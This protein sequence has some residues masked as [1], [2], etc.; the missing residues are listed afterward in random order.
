M[1]TEL[2]TFLGAILG[3]GVVTAIVNNLF[4]RKKHTAESGKTDAERGKVSAESESVYVANALAAVEPLRAI[5][6]DLQANAETMRGELKAV[7]DDNIKL[8]ANDEL[9]TEEIGLLQRRERESIQAYAALSTWGLMAVES[10]RSQGMTLPPMPEL[11]P[12][13]QERTRS[14]DTNPALFRKGDVQ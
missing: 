14:T 2:L 9:K 4:L 6:R 13:R 1:S 3:G 7:R 5:V 10:A 11:L 12:P 8:H